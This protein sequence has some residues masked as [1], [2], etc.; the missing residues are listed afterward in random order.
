MRPIN[1]ASATP[2]VL[3]TRANNY[4]PARSIDPYVAVPLPAQSI[5]STVAIE[6]V[7][8]HAQLK[9]CLIKY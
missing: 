8:Q 9:E 1:T 7:G 3:P 6:K 5:D 2:S 4:M